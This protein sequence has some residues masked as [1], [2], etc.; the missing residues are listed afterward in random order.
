MDDEM[1]GRIL[2]R[3]FTLL[4]PTRRKVTNYRNQAIS[5]L[6]EIF[7]GWPNW[8]VERT[9]KGRRAPVPELSVLSALRQ[10]ETMHRQWLAARRKREA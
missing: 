1:P 4:Q 5:C 9:K 3:R 7:T 8:R 2:S 6:S 10:V